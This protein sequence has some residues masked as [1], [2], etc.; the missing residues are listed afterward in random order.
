MYEHKSEPL[1][2]TRVFVARVARSALV[3]G[4]LVVVALAVGTVGYRAT[5]DLSWI[6]ALLN[7][8]MILS[9]EGPVSEL[10]SDGGKLFAVAYCF[11]STA[12]LALTLGLLG[13]PVAHR[14]L[15]YLHLESGEARR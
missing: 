10:H 13:A 15:H 9:G 1:I 4:V 11:F 3:V 2:P 6:D 7:A 5:E 8:A 12:V 14:V